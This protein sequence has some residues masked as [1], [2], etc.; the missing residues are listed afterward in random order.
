MV[1][2]LM[3]LTEMV[4]AQGADLST[5]ALI[6]CSYEAH[7]P[8]VQLDTVE[9]Q[10]MLELRMEIWSSEVCWVVDCLER[11]RVR[12]RVQVGGKASSVQIPRPASRDCGST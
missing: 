3:Q 5:I 8:P 1:E 4:R 11:V 6:P 10:E 7:G 2:H 9:G 12:V